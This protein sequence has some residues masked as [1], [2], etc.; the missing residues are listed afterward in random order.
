MIAE[1][2]VTRVEQLLAEG[3]LS[4]RK[5][6]REIGVSRGTIGAIASGRR[7]IQPRPKWFLEDEPFVPDTPPK[8]CPQCGGMVYMPCR[9][10]RTREMLAVS[11]A[12]QT[13]IGPHPNPLPKGEGMFRA[14]SIG[15][16]SNLLTKGEGMFGA[17]ASRKIA[18]LGLDLKSVHRE[19]YEEVRRWRRERGIGD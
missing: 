11:A 4:H 1:Q 16:H 14:I 9:A 13:L 18:P 8:R 7:N 10:C 3:N 2:I 12:K 6:A 17:I 19:R 5:I 15:P